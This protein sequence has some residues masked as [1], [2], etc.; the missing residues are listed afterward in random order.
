MNL[1]I[2]GMIILFISMGFIA[3]F[4]VFWFIPK[5]SAKPTDPYPLIIT[6]W[7]GLVSGV[8]GSIGAALSKVEEV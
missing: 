2:I 1:K 6:V 3:F 7:W 5:L 4:C 8:V